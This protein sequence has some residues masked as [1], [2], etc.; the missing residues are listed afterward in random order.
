MKALEIHFKSGSSL[1]VDATD[2]SMKRLAD[3]L[4]ELG[5]TSPH[6][7]KRKLF[8]AFNLS[9]IVALVVIK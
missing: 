4:T 3:E 8:A 2:V 9:E 5:W 6:D 1:T 7:A